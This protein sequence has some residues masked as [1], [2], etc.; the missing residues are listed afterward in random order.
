MCLRIGLYYLKGGILN[1]TWQK[2][3][4]LKNKMTFLLKS[5][6]VIAVVNKIVIVIFGL[7]IALLIT[8]KL[9]PEQQGLHFL[10]QSLIGFSALAEMGVIYSVIQLTSKAVGL[11]SMRRE[12][13]R[14]MVGGRYLFF[15]I[16]WFVLTSIVLVLILGPF[17]H[18]WILS[19]RGFSYSNIRPYIG[20]WYAL[21]F[22]NSI[23]LL[24]NGILGFLEGY[25]DISGA[26]FCRLITN[27]FY[28]CTIAF[29]M[30]CGYE[31]KSIVFGSCIGNIALL[32]LLY[33]KYGKQMTTLFRLAIIYKLQ[34]NW[35]KEIKPFQTKISISWLSGFISNQVTLPLI[36]RYLGS[37][38]AGRIGL[39]LQLCSVL[40]GVSIAWPLASASKLARAF[41]LKNYLTRQNIFNADVKVST[42]IFAILAVLLLLSIKIAFALNIFS[43]DRV[44][45]LGII[46]FILIPGALAAHLNNSMAIYIRSTGIEPL[47]YCSVV[48]SLVAFLLNLY[49]IPNYGHLG[50]VLP[51][52]IVSILICLPWIYLHY[53]KDFYLYPAEKM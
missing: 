28:H 48:T 17:G 15:T 21:V 44:V 47:T 3:Y 7:V 33:F 19:G 27:S 22:S 8:A 14:R 30:Y 11:S 29:S 50:A 20:F 43:A 34:V 40:N 38:D 2:N 26:N 39:S 16:K 45:S 13:N 18:Y 42:T 32:F 35:S 36:Y 6:Q 24:G 46:T 1:K 25:G 9:T 37:V 4:K 31:A 12:D 52:A 53:K 10:F 51:N 5:H 23:T 41:A 49:C